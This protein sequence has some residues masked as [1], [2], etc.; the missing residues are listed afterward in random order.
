MG[1]ILF[2]AHRIPF[3]PNRGDKIRSHHVL[4]ALAQIAPVHVGCLAD[5]AQDLAEAAAL[6]DIA[7]S[8][9]LVERRKKLIWAGLEA[10]AKGLPVSLAAFHDRKLERWVSETLRRYPI[11]TIYAFSAQMGQYIPPDFAGRVVFDFVDVEFCEVR[12][13]CPG[14]QMAAPVDRS[15]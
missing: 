9:C 12:G 5:D 10:V 14:R 4:R 3:P 7:A 6:A 8:Y 2:L 11:S 15:A 13:L 1:D